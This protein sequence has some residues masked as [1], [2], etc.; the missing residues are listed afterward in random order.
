MLG[1]E[2]IEEW[3]GQEVVDVEGERVGKLQEVY[4]STETD[5]AV[6][7]L[8]KS[9]IFGRHMSL[10]PLTGASV[11]RDYLRLAYSTKQIAQA[12]SDVEVRETLDANAARQV[13]SSYGIESSDEDLESATSINR[14]TRAAREAEEQANELDEQARRRA[15]EAGEAHNNAQEA[16]ELAR[17]KAE[18]AEQARTDAEE[19][20]ARADGITPPEAPSQA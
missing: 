19:A 14:R 13:A 15:E 20:H 16:A 8:V 6:M 1:V 3:L 5:E 9:G 2:Q 18:T 7:A 4:Y 11:G 12:G 10:V 17:R